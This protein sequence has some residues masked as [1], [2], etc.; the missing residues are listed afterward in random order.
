M[1]EA[2]P[3]AGLDIK[4]IISAAPDLEADMAAAL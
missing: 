2:R 1:C 4:E 3:D